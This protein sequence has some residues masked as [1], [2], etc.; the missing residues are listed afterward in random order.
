M[1]YKGQ[2]L[3]ADFLG[4]LLVAEYSAQNVAGQML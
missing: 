1:T 2:M 4:W 3:S